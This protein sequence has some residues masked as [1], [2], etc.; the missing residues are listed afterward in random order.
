[1]PTPRHPVH[2]CILAIAGVAIAATTYDWASQSPWAWPAAHHETPQEARHLQEQA[3]STRE[4]LRRRNAGV[5]FADW[6]PADRDTW[7]SCEQTLEALRQRH[8]ELKENDGGPG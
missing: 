4:G 7:R 5:P 1:V 3:L 6:H 8:P 2:G